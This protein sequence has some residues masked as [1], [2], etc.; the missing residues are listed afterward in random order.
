MLN[1]QAR[2]LQTQLQSVVVLPGLPNCMTEE[3][4]S[5]L[6][7]PK[8][9]ELSFSTTAF[10][11]DLHRSDV[12][13]PIQLLDACFRAGVRALLSHSKITPSQNLR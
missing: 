6:T 12:S 13:W 11:T 3:M 2:T 7:D 4:L 9:R 1:P 8:K 5:R 10:F